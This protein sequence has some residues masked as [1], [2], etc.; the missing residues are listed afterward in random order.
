VVA[1]AGALMAASCSHGTERLDATGAPA[2]GIAAGYAQT[3]ALTMA[4]EVECWGYNH[5]GQLGDGTTVDRHRPVAVIGLARGVRAVAAGG[6]HSCA[7]T[8]TRA[9][10]CWGDNAHGE[11]GHGTTRSSLKPLVVAGLTHRVQGIAAGEAF[12]CALTRSGRVWCW[13]DNRHGELGDGTKATRERPVSVVGL[14]SGVVAIALGYLHACALTRAGVVECWGYNRYGQL[15]DGTTT[16]RLVPV[17]VSG[18]ASVAAISAGGGHTCALTR[19]GAVMCWGSN[20]Y[21]ELGDGTTTRRP[22]PVPVSGLAGSATAIAAGGEAHG[23]ALTLGDEVR[24]WGYNGHGQLGDGT[25]TDRSVP[26]ALVGLAAG[27]RAITT[28]GFGHTCAIRRGGE[29][30]CWGRNS[31]GQ[32]GDG[33]TSDRHTP[34]PV[35]LA[36]ASRG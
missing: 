3:C 13:G 15:G 2:T 29:V 36:S 33:T 6:R 18:L 5:Y 16:D 21:G 27:A 35:R 24:C 19:G 10:E 17:R 23:C 34:V 25:T 1:L 12:A 7:L 22:S 28:G 32:L 8:R 26:V 30:V 4:G 31:S 9:V 20:R 11:L 14:G